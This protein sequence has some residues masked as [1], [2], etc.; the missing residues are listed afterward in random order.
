M[1]MPIRAQRH[2]GFSPL[3]V[4]RRSLEHFGPA[5]FRCHLDLGVWDQSGFPIRQLLQTV[6]NLVTEPCVMFRFLD[7]FTHEVAQKLR[8]RPIMRLGCLGEGGFQFIF[9]AEGEG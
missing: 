2:R 1:M 7:V 9:H 6:T 4:R 5:S 8:T 3:P